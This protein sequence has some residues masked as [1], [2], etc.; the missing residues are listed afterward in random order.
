M[1]DLKLIAA[2]KGT[3]FAIFVRSPHYMP[4]A[5]QWLYSVWQEMAEAAREKT[6]HNLS[7]EVSY[8][9]GLVDDPPPKRDWQEADINAATRRL[10]AFERAARPAKRFVRITH[11]S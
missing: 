2:P 6:M 7:S 3:K 9:V 10:R 5:V 4:W 11:E 1:N 8:A